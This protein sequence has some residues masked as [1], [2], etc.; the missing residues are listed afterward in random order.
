[1]AKSPQGVSRYWFVEPSDLETR[2]SQDY[3]EATKTSE[4]LFSFGAEDPKRSPAMMEIINAVAGKS[5][6][7]GYFPR[8]N[9]TPA[10][11]ENLDTPIGT[12]IKSRRT[13]RK[14]LEKPITLEELS[15]LLV[16]GAGINGAIGIGENTSRD[17]RTYPSGGGLYPLEIYPI[18]LNVEGVEEGVYHFDVRNQCINCLESGDVRTKVKEAYLGEK[19]LEKAAVCFFVTA[20]FKR[21]SFKYGERA[22]RLVNIEAGHLI[23]NVMYVGQALGLSIIPINGFFDRRLEK[24]INVDGIEESILYTAIGGCV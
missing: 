20:I 23:H 10:T 24:L 8:I 18:I 16:Y 3:H 11:W 22:Y 1:M 9:L 7:Y 19:M 21:T 13:N 6:N 12:L 15:T 5:K 2:L 4:F 17:G 14:L